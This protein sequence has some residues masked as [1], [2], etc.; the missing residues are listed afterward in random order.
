ML[1]NFNV[2]Q[3]RIRKKE[4]KMQSDVT[5]MTVMTRRKKEC[6]LARTRAR[7]MPLEVTPIQMLTPRNLY[8]SAANI[9]DD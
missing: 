1:A 5:A 9:P 6:S 4:H 7:E 8:G 2:K 3:F